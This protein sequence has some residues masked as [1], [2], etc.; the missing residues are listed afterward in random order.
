MILSRKNVYIHDFASLIETNIC[1]VDIRSYIILFQDTQM[2]VS[3]T[4]ATGFIG[5]RLVQKLLAGFN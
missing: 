1:P 5:R 2:V 3:I 4:G